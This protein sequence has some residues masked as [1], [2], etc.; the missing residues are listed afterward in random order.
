M[1]RTAREPK[2]SV[3][4]RVPFMTRSTQPCKDAIVARNT[5]FDRLASISL[6]GLVLLGTSGCA[7]GSYVQLTDK[8]LIGTW[9]HE[10]TGGEIYKLEFGA[11]HTARLSPLPTYVSSD[12]VRGESDANGSWEVEKVSLGG[13]AVVITTS[14]PPGGAQ[15]GIEL[16][17][18]GTSYDIAL[19]LYIGDPDSGN[20]V[21][22]KRQE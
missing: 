18:T 16:F 22:Y 7:A 5:R 3:P 2:D 1:R 9:T 10:E 13:P 4:V 17:Q 19:T 21:D 20:Q 6:L 15:Q 8:Q 12:E 11:D 14:N